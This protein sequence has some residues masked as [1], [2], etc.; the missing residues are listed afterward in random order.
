MC[1]V[2]ACLWG[3]QSLPSYVRWTQLAEAPNGGLGIS[4]L[5]TLQGDLNSRDAVGGSRAA[6][7]ELPNSKPFFSHSELLAMHANPIKHSAMVRAC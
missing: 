2:P 5:L 6:C 4:V 7:W 1:E 3:W